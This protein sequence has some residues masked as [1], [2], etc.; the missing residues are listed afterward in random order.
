VRR[1]LVRGLEVSYRVSQRRAC[2]VLK[3]NRSTHRYRSVADPLVELGMR[4]KELAAARVGYG[5]RRLHILL[6]REGW[7]VNHK[8]LYRLYREEGLAMRRKPP[9]R[10]VSCLKRESVRVTK[11]RNECW[12]MDFVSD[13]LYDG[14]RIRV[15]TLVDNHTRESLCLHVAQRV[16]GLDVVEQLERVTAERGFPK[17]I[18]VDNGPEFISK[19]VDMWAYWNGVKLDFIRP[20]K[21]TDNAF[22][23]SFNGRFRQECLNEH[24]FLSLEDAEE[25]IEA[26]RRDYNEHRPHS[27]LGNIPPAEFA[28]SGIPSASAA[29]QPQEYRV[30]A[31]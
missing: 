12:S 16:R 30:S 29:L 21:P 11:S 19:A 3:F 17:M 18:R 13:E 5:Y 10:R 22:I 4:L 9:R 28:A 15:F 25:K 14:R 8:R 6:E 20:G 7:R 1:D 2:K 27:S 26:W 31:G 23:E 24:W